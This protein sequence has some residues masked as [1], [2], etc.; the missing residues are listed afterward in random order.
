[1]KKRGDASSN[2]EIEGS[3]LRPAW[4]FN[5][6]GG[7]LLDTHYHSGISVETEIY[8]STRK[9]PRRRRR[10]VR[11]KESTTTAS[12]QCKY[13]DTE[14]MNKKKNTK[15]HRSVRAESGL[16]FDFVVAKRI[17]P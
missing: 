1:M 13:P 7:L 17:L 12:A 8:I 4:E 2:E 9:I 6:Q 3:D 11:R 14:G 15:Q 10:S 16:G 5:L